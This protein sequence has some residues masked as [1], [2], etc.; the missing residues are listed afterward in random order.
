LA[1]TPLTLITKR[2]TM[3]LRSAEE[4]EQRCH[5]RAASAETARRLFGDGADRPLDLV[6]RGAQQGAG[7]DFAALALS[8]GTQQLIVRAAVGV[9]AE[10]VLGTVVDVHLNGHMLAQLGDCITAPLTTGDVVVGLL[11]VGRVPGRPAFTESDSDRLAGFALYVAVALEL[12]RIRTDLDGF[13]IADHVIGELYTLGIGLQGLVSFQVRPAHR[14]RLAGYVDR[15][16]ALVRRVRASGN[17]RSGHTA[18]SLSRKLLTVAEAESVANGLPVRVEF[19]DRLDFSAELD[20]RVVSVVRDALR[21]VVRHANASGVRLSV[22]AV[23]GVVTVEIAHDGL[24]LAQT[25][26]DALARYQGVLRQT[27]NGGGTHLTWTAQA[28]AR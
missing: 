15:V 3:D 2:E 21:N 17:G 11:S 22:T 16:D 13:R 28:V 12:D 1:E 24:D 25:T 26:I 8:A 19:G 9:H 14:A 6:L 23:D 7:A 4:S 5:W 20:D 27:T 10:L 18:E